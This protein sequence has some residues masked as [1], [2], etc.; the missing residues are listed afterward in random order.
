MGLFGKI[1]NILFE[2]EDEEVVMPDYSSKKEEKEEKK[3]KEVKVKK[4]SF[5]DDDFEDS[6][7]IKVKEHK[8][9]DEDEDLDDILDELPISSKK[10]NDFDEEEKKE[11]E[12]KSPFLS[13]DED[14]FERLNVR[15]TESENKPRSRFSERID[16]VKLPESSNSFARKANGNI[17]ATKP[18]TSR[19]TR[20]EDRYKI[21]L[22]EMKNKKFTP[23]P[24]ISPVYGVLN[25]NYTKEDIIDKK[26]GLKRERVKPLV[27]KKETE[28]PNEIKNDL[29][30]EVDIDSVRKKAYGAME[31]LEKTAVLDK[32]LKNIQE[33]NEDVISLEEKEK[34]I[35]SKEEKKDLKDIK[36]IKEVKEVV[37]DNLSV[38]DEIDELDQV[39]SSHFD[40]IE[41]RQT[42]GM[43]EDMEEEENKP[44]LLDDLEKT[45]TL[46][47]LD[48][49]EREL[50][51]IKPISKE[52]DD[53]DEKEEKID[54]DRSDTLENDLFN[55][56][57]SMYEE[58]DEEDD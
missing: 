25:K 40:N 33:E 19:D 11:E 56:I 46:Q 44:Q 36:E 49:I 20:N 4:V 35:L 27:S 48:D 41:E 54:E 32:E 16:D 7:P 15:V 6:M 34:A 58:G 45:S 42:V 22:D 5:D 43:L 55:L 51:S 2:D 30:I 17:S 8:K 13:F 57:D 31:D 50:N 18:I 24:V 47:I 3:E 52:L 53:N 12:K 39:I 14:E 28:V 1:K 21:N 23:S 10:K 29:P 9:K 37:K 26:D 38:E